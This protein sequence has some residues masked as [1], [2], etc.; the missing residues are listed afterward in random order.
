MMY[1]LRGAAPRIELP[2]LPRDDQ[3]AS[4]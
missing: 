1:F 3:P 4:W 2:G